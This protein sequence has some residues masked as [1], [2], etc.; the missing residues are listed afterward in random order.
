MAKELGPKVGKAPVHTSAS[1]STSCATW[2]KPLDFS[3]LGF[4]SWKM[5]LIRASIY[6]LGD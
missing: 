2:G 3:D 5:E 6:L 4:H 1:P